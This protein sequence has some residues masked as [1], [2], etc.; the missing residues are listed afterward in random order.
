[1]KR[2][3]L[4]SILLSF[5]LIFTA[6]VH[7]QTA[8]DGVVIN[9]VDPQ[10]EG[11]AQGVQIYFTLLDPAGRAAAVDSV[12]SAD[13]VLEDQTIVPATINDSADSPFFIALALDLSGSM[14]QDVEQMVAAAIQA[15]ETAPENA[16][17]SIVRFNANVTPSAFLSRE[18][19]IAEVEKITIADSQGGTKLYD[20]TY[21]SI[22]LV[23]DATRNIPAHRAVIVFTDGRDEEIQGTG[24]QYS[25][26][27]VGDV[28]ALAARRE[29]IVPI[30]T[31]GLGANI[32]PRLPDIAESSGGIAVI[33]ESGDLAEPFKQIMNNLRSQWLGKVVVCTAAGEQDATFRVRIGG[34]TV[35]TGISFNVDI[36]C[37]PENLVP[38]VFLFPLRANRPQNLYEMQIEAE[39]TILIANW[40]L[41][42]IDND[43]DTVAQRVTMPIA[44]TDNYSFT[45]ENLK[46]GVNYAVELYALDANNEYLRNE[47]NNIKLAT[48]TFTH[49]NNTE[50]AIELPEIVLS[51]V[52][53]E[54]EL[55]SADL[56]GE[57][58]PLINNV[59]WQL[60]GVGANNLISLPDPEQL[61]DSSYLFDISEIDLIA[62]DYQLWVTAYDNNDFPL[63]SEQSEAISY[64]PL[65]A[66]RIWLNEF[67]GS[68]AFYLLLLFLLLLL[69][70]FLYWLYRRRK[71]N[72]GTPIL[73]GSG[74]HAAANSQVSQTLMGAG[75]F[76]DIGDFWDEEPIAAVA[77]IGMI[78]VIETPGSNGKGRPTQINHTP[79]TIGREN[80]D[81]NF[82]SDWRVSR[83]H[84]QIIRT[85]NDFFL[86]DLGSSNGTFITDQEI[87]KKRPVK[88]NG[89]T[90][91][92]LGKSTIVLFE[93]K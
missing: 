65:P 43:D 6:T 62:D 93:T 45:P 89:R 24:I 67:I 34:K 50:I 59:S 5:F 76:D 57:D 28:I 25:D 64:S 85:D 32:D 79:F 20:A 29:A 74:V 91:I 31:I 51:D 2:F 36:P 80:C 52:V 42:I 71:A 30:Y 12:D 22:T 55:L 47:R 82:G 81:L 7:S 41:H 19:A 73:S 8:V 83:R 70:L 68:L 48:E 1:M 61:E 54:R 44:E 18:D 10:P 39:N 3:S 11:E 14:R 35:Q 90:S 66:W 16:R 38:E 9:Y 17:I 27:S 49:W 46:A 60:F 26:N 21:E 84:A 4:V 13:V 86:E 37:E 78:T 23:A 53:L 56:E 77:K 69:V 63:D 92:R 87:A 72:S 58:D 33:G 15:I 40:E 75:E 88:L